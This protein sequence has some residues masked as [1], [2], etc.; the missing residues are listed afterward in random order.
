MTHIEG[1]VPLASYDDERSRQSGHSASWKILRDAISAG[2][3]DGFQHG[4]SKRWLVNKIQADK[5]LRARAAKAEIDAM[6]DDGEGDVM[7]CLLNIESMLSA[8]SD[9]LFE[10]FSEKRDAAGCAEDPNEETP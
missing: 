2:E 3:I 8:I 1:F 5:Y 6:D 9:L 10:R 7:V 4:G